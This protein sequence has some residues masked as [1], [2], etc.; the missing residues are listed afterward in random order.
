MKPLTPQPAP[1]AAK[2]S[3]LLVARVPHL[4]A[5]L[6]LAANALTLLV[7]HRLE[8]P[9]VPTFTGPRVQVPV[10]LLILGV[11]VYC[12]LIIIQRTHSAEASLFA[13]VVHQGTREDP[14]QEKLMALLLIGLVQWS[15]ALTLEGVW[16]RFFGI[17]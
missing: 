1:A 10:H 2:I 4:L 12:R 15:I 11:W 7:L 9:G 5:W 13:K 3:A 8:V 16:M 17:W 14:W 6:M